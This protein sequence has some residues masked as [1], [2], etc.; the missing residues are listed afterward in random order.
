MYTTMA[1]VCAS[2][3]NSDGRLKFVSAIDMMQDCSQMWM[4]SEPSV[5]K[6]FRENN[7]SQMLVSRQVD[8]KRT[9]RYGE[10]LV[11]QTSVYE[12]KG[13]QGYR[14]TVVYD[15]KNTPCFVSWSTGAFV[16]P[17]DGKPARVP[18]DILDNLVV[19]EKVTMEYLGRKIP[20]PD[21]ECRNF[22]SVTVK[23]HDIDFNR[24][25]NNARYVQ[26]A[27]EYLPPDFEI[28][29]FRIEYKTPA[30]YGE[31]LHPRMIQIDPGT[32]YIILLNEN[33]DSSAV[34]EFS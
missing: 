4:E 20:L 23:K 9:P 13:F 17:S 32:I 29:R 34:M 24:H 27:V 30:K 8:V 26:I 3:T 5:E 6:Y 12:C 11:V 16:N 33:A 28:N 21:R 15:E 19:D 1:R 18:R 14:N 10:R 22:P 7:L 25:M 2:H 31:V